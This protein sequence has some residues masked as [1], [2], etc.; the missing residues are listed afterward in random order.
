MA[1]KHLHT[2]LK[3]GE[4]LLCSVRLMKTDDTTPLWKN[5]KFLV[6]I[7]SGANN[8]RHLKYTQALGRLSWQILVKCSHHVGLAF[9]N[10]NFPAIAIFIS[11]GPVKERK[12]WNNMLKRIIYTVLMVC[13]LK[14]ASSVSRQKYW[15]ISVRRNEDDKWF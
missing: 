3:M 14:I 8:A 11:D 13:H 10:M 1:T 2:R 9:R 12:G 5:A 7:K 6:V 4:S 15:C